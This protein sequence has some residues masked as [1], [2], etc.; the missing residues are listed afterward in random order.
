[1]PCM[2]IFYIAFYYSSV[3]KIKRKRPLKNTKTIERN[4]TM[5]NKTF[6]NHQKN[7]A[8]AGRLW[9]ALRCK[10]DNQNILLR[11]AVA[12]KSVIDAVDFNAVNFF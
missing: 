1:M 9:C 8:I 11:L 4:F 3:K 12:L 5:N 6:S 7:D 2:D 10:I